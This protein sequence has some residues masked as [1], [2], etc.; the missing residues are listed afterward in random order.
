M[1]PEL[2]D[3]WGDNFI[4]NFDYAKRF[5]LWSEDVIGVW[6]VGCKGVGIPKEEDVTATKKWNK[7]DAH[8]KR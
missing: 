8:C 3:N 2:A 7:S 1:G 6:V 5:F 4:D